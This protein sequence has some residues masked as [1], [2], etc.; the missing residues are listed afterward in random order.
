M[1]FLFE[2]SAFSTVIKSGAI[3]VNSSFSS[4]TFEFAFEPS[5]RDSFC[6]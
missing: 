5:E 6:L 3:S 4:P 1:L 2:K